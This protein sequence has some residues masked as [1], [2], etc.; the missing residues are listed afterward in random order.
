[1]DEGGGRA[2]AEVGQETGESITV[3]P[4]TLGICRRIW[5]SFLGPKMD[6]ELVK[7]DIGC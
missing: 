1:M 4:S 6:V 3:V 2:A 5:I 7:E